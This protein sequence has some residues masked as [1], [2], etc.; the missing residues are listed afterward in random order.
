MLEQL[1]QKDVTNEEQLLRKTELEEKRRKH[2]K[3]IQEEKKTLTIDRILNVGSRGKEDGEDFEERQEG[4]G[5]EA[6]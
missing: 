1:R 3:K 6:L 5:L 2:M 4:R